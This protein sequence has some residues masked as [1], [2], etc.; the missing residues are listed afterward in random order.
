MKTA[1]I[2]IL[3]AFLA[4]SAA[5]AA[6]GTLIVL[7][8]S[9]ATASLI[10][11]ST[12]KAV[13]AVPTGEGPHEVAVSGDGRRA[14]VTNYGPARKPGS[15]VTLIDIPGAKAIRTID[16]GEYRRPHGVQFLSDERYAVVTAEANHALL[17]VN[18]RSGQVTK[19]GDT[20][21]LTSH[22]VVVRPRG[23]RAY[24]AN[25]GSGSMTAID[26]LK[27]D[28]LK[29]VKTGDGAEGITITP[30]GSQVWVTN[31]QADTVSVVDAESLKIVETFPVA[32]FPIRV[33]ITPDGKRAL[34]SCARSGDVAV[35]D[36]ASRREVGRISMELKAKADTEGRL[37]S[38]QFGESSVPVGILIAP[39]GK[40]AYVAHTQA[41]AVS[42]IDLEKGE[43]VD[44]L[45]PGKEPDGLG[46]SP[47]KVQAGQ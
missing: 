44:R 1:S 27:K 29:T 45:T 46:Y 7:N 47:L 16:L 2:F 38:E 33:K 32:A 11:L 36:V 40:R 34:I 23:D 4:V 25:I 6:D 21:Q 3:A 22:M 39:D 35:V 19:V 17:L 42:V 15:S 14:L 20:E 9:E 41:D 30:D 13:A 5:A 10:D 26:I 28:R 18:V 12:G 43:V 8:K 37:F 24:V 31:R